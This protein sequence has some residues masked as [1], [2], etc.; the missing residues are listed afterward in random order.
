MFWCLVCVC[1]LSLK[2]TC[3]CLNLGVHAAC[4]FILI[5]F[6]SY[7]WCSIFIPD[8]FPCVSTSL[9][10]LQGIYCLFFLC[11]LTERLFSCTYVC[12]FL[13]VQVSSVL[14]SLGFLFSCLFQFCVLIIA[15]FLTT[16]LNK[17]LVFN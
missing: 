1:T 6:V 15:L 4:S 12:K 3:P 2:P 13:I 9:I 16:S 17:R 8:V 5:T 10:T 7:G 14:P 11:P